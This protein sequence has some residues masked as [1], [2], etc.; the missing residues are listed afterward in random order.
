ME[1]LTQFRAIDIPPAVKSLNI[2]QQDVLMKYI[3]AGLQLPEVYNSAVL[4]NW[5]EKVRCECCHDMT[6]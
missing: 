3:Y 1:V 2:D 6:I 5:H 4:L